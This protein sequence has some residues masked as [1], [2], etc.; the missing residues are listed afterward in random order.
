MKI[1][2]MGYSGAGK[3]TL[4]DLLGENYSLPVLH[5]DATFWFG[6]WQHRTREEQSAIVR[7]FMADNADG[8]VIDGNYQKICLERFSECDT[9]YFLNYNRLFCLTQAIKRYKKYKG[10]TRPDCPCPEKFDLE[11]LC[12]ILFKC[13]TRKRRRNYKEI[14]A[15]SQGNKF[16]FKKRKQLKKHLSTL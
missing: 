15:M 7:K 4:A 14:L 12:W 3:S 1:G 16:I 11:F 8:W 13:R 10:C 9:V 2:V 6:D 5:L